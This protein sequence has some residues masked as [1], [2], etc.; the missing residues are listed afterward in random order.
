MVDIQ[1]LKKR[2]VLNFTKGIHSWM[3]KMSN[4][5]LKAWE[6]SAFERARKMFE[7]QKREY[8]QDEAAAYVRDEA[9]LLERDYTLF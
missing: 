3:T 4:E 7:E 5:E 6:D 1:E 8:R 9:R 2:P